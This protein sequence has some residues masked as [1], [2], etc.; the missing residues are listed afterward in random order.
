[1][2]CLG[3]LVVYIIGLKYNKQCHVLSVSWNRNL[4]VE[5]NQC[6]EVLVISNAM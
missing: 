4:N 1:M 5:P 6:Q 2:G 3:R